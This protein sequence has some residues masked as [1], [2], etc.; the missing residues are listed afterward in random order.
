LLSCPFCEIEPGR[1]WIETED[2]I[3]FPDAY[4]V[5]DGHMLVVP[6]KHVSTMYELTMPE[7]KAIWSLVGQ[8]SERLLTGLK[9]D[10]FNIGFNDGLAAEQTVL[11]AHV[12]IIP[13]RHGDVP[14]PRGGIRWVI[15]DNAPYWKK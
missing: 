7:Q 13:R 5:A 14:D 9:P 15:A 4:P 2:A 12:H 8:V 1:I 10:G 6:R 3:A 11:H